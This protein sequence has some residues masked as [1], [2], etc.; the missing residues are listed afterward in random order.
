MRLYRSVSYFVLLLVL[1]IS[2]HASTHDTIPS[3]FSQKPSWKIGV[4]INPV[5]V[6]G[7]NSFLKGNNNELKKVRAGLSGDIR[8]D[9]SFAPDTKEGVLY[10]DLYQGVGIGVNSLFSNKLLG[11]P[12]TAYIYQG[13]PIVHLSNRLWVGYEWKFGAAFGWK[14]YDEETA[15]NNAVVSTSVTAMLG[16]GVKLHYS[17]SDR[18]TLSAG[19][20]AVH[21]SNG[22]TSWPNAGVN[23][24][25]AA[26]GI[27]YILNQQKQAISSPLWLMEEADRGRWLYD[28]MIFGAW[29]KRAVNI[30]DNPQ[31]CPGKFGIAGIQISPLRQFNRWLAAGPALDLQWD[32][33]AGLEPYWI[34]GTS[35]DN[36]KF[37]RPPFGKQLS[38]GISAHAELTMPIFSVNAGIGYDI[39]N[40]KGEKRFYQ[41][42]TLKTFLTKN[43][44]LNVGYRLGD[45]KDP[46]N[47]MLGVGVRL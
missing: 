45:F 47:L 9:F 11:T 14:H 32:E 40:P 26:I 7:T 31:I 36:V 33:S 5:W 2:A 17:L 28:I 34:E 18:W 29:R 15:D 39:I 42:L 43:I 12:I 23:S 16:A 19:V 10:P 35:G 44:F 46:Q 21:Y 22:N 13:A 41:S 1:G 20:T 37:E 6:P 30:G 8:A 24:I 27:S 4:E 38:V 3:G 25:G